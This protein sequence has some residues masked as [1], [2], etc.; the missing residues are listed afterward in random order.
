MRRT[1]AQMSA[2]PNADAAKADMLARARLDLDEKGFCIVPSVLSQIQLSAVRDR[3]EAQ[4]EAERAR[5]LTLSQGRRDGS[6]SGAGEG[7]NQRILMLIN[8]GKP[9]VDL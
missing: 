7:E 6:Y 3:I 9:F 5:G 2:A 8:K 1:Q 4:A